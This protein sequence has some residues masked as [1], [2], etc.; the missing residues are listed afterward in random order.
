M[1]I[2]LTGRTALITGASKGL[3]LAMA[4]RMAASGARVVMLARGRGDLESAAAEI[5]A[6]HPIACD[7]T[8]AAARDAAVAEAL[9]RF[10]TIDILVNNAGSSQRG[11]VEDA[12]RDRMIEDMDLKLHAPLALTRA[13]LP[14]M[15]AQ[16]WGRVLNV[17]AIVGK[18]PDG[19]SLPTSV[20]RGAGIT[21][22]KALSKEL[23]PWNV[24][25]NALCVG[26]IKSGQWER[27]F[28]A[29]G[30]DDY[31]AFL[32]P[33]AD[34]VPLKRLGEAEEFANVACF[35]AS[36]AASY[37]TGTAINVDG[38]LCAVT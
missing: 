11:P 1:Q 32:K 22:T 17:T 35:L 9:D 14:G 7:I 37:V 29:S 15:K 3:G 26:K 20:S 30:Q 21:L 8:D 10:G 25:V 28:A 2:D 5:A 33:T 27:R 38:G 19:G 36:D 6:A 12:T 16:H 24:L 31:E 34:K 18:T 4:R 13:V 23:A